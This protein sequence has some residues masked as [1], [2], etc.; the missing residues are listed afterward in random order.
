MSKI[1]KY[2]RI[3]SL[4]E[5]KKDEKVCAVY[6]SPIKNTSG[7]KT[8]EQIKKAAKDAKEGKCKLVIW[9]EC[10]DEKYC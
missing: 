3:N 5:A 4:K 10:E 9:R 8:D 7:K 1:W 6:P 2:V